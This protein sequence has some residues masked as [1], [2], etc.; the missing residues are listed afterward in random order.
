MNKLT[1]NKSQMRKLKTN[2]TKLQKLTL[3]RKFCFD[4]GSCFYS[5]VNSEHK[6]T[7]NR[8][9]DMFEIED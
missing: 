1:L 3:R 9:L 8:I 4:S 7:L 5:D 6:K 2:L